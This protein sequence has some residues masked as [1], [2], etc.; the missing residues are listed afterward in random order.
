MDFAEH[1]KK[2]DELTQ[3]KRKEEE[4]S[5]VFGEQKESADELYIKSCGIGE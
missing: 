4:I 5:R 1:L 3:Q 2:I